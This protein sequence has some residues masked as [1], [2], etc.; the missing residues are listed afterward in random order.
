[1]RDVRTAM[2]ARGL[3]A[4][5]ID[6][7]YA[8]VAEWIEV[9]LATQARRPLMVGV[10]GPQGCG[11]STLAAAIV[12][13]FEA[14]G[15]AAIS[16]SIDDFYLRRDE[17][18]ALAARHPGDRT[19]EH[20][21]YPGT[22]DVALGADVLESLRAGAPTTIP[23]Y[24]KSAHEGRGDRAEPGAWTRVDRRLDL[25]IV[26]GWLVGFTPL[27]DR[28]VSDELR[29]TNE[30]LGAYARWWT[31]LDALVIA[32]A[33]RLEAIV[34]WRV[35]AERGRRARG[36]AALSDADAL[37]YIR[38]F[39]PAYAAWVP[40]LVARSRSARCLSM[41]LGDDR[42]PISSTRR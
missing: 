10:S 21:G 32:H 3:D 22:H 2:V 39:L 14:T 33:Q 18:L 40:P 7:I 38:R 24:D 4:T 25:V 8:P 34:E 41:Q 9:L 1:M 27:D 36:E 16:V 15:R 26:E 11:K 12:G 6:R 17:Q 31:T 37:D 29:P 5:R 35:D 20:R 23:R 30:L 42:S 19:L 13:A 28:D